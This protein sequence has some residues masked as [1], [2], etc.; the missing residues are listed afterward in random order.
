MTAVS[1]V[2]DPGLPST[3][4]ILANVALVFIMVKITGF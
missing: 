4:Y 3:A 1:A 2:E